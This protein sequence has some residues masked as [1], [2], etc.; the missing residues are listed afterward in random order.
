[1]GFTEGDQEITE[2]QEK[3]YVDSLTKVKNRQ[4]YDEHLAEKSLQAIVVADIDNFK[5]VN[6]TYGHEVGDKVLSKLVRILKKN[7]RSDDYICR[8]GGDEFVIFMIHA[9]EKQQDLISR[10]FSY[11]NEKLA[12]T[13]DGLPKI[14]TSAGIAFGEYASDIKDWF[15]HADVALYDAKKNGKSCFVF[16]SGQTGFDHSKH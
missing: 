14:S 11:I 1:M 9:G 2:R 7:F 12:D 16:Y 3:I 6:D 10:K 4:Y 15:E 5:S 8:I 13:S